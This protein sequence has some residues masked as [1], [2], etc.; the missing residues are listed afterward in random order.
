MAG[1]VA[2]LRPGHAGAP[3]VHLSW[4][5]NLATAAD[6]V[7]IPLCASLAVVDASSGHLLDQ[8]VFPTGAVAAGPGAETSTGACACLLCA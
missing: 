3:R 7:G 1:P 8:R 2:M 6:A 5:T 4:F